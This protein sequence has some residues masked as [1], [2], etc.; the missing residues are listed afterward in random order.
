M[1]SM[2]AF[3]LFTEIEFSFNA[4]RASPFDFKNPEIE[5]NKSIIDTFPAN[6]DL[7]I[8]FWGTPSKISIKRELLN[9]L[10]AST[11]ASPFLNKIEDAS[12]A[13]L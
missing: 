13:A 5:D 3:F 11:A 2:D 9:P 1:K 7:V 12:T 6:S 4:L 10:S 8:S